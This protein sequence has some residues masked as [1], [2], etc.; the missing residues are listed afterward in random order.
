MKL[1]VGLLLSHG[2]PAPSDFWDSYELVMNHVQTGQTNAMLPEHLRFEGCS[3][4]KS[5]GFPPDV[6]RNEIV[7]GFLDTSNAQWLLF[8]DCDMTFP[9]DIVAK[10]M[11]HEKPVISGRYHMRKPPHRACAFVKHRWKDGPHAYQAVHFGKGLIEIERGGAGALLIRRDVLE[12]IRFRIGDNWFR[13]Q[14][15][16][17]DPHDFTVSEDFWF[18]QQARESGYTCWCDWDVECGHLQMATINGTWASAYLDAEFR[19][20]P[21]LSDEKRIEQLNSYVVCGFPDGLTLP[22]GDHVPAYTYQPGER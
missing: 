1:A 21:S 15:G 14:R 22:T 3:R 12:A 20:L 4:L 17:T 7:R 13:Y 11:V 18:Y 5:T 19:E 6:A 2:F 10:L 8:L 16:P 9:V